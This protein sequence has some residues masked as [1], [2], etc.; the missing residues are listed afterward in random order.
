MTD[1]D[2]IQGSFSSVKEWSMGGTVF[3]QTW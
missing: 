1:Q 2:W 3:W